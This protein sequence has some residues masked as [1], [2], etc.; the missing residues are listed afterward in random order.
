[1]NSFEI[2]KYCDNLKIAKRDQ[3]AEDTLRKEYKELKHLSDVFTGNEEEKEGWFNDLL[4]DMKMIETT[5][6]EIGVT[7]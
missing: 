3:T 5:F 4:A 7:I 6:A 2:K 1:M